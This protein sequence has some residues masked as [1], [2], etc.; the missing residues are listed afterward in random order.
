MGDLSTL[1]TITINTLWVIRPLCGLGRDFHP[2]GDPS[3]LWTN[4]S[5]LWVIRPLCGLGNNSHPMSGPSTFW[6]LF[7]PVHF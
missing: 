7:F 2:M 6:V 5:T 1:W 3:T 4:I